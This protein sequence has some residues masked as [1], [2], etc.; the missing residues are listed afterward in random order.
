[1]RR[2]VCFLDKRCIRLTYSK[3]NRIKKFMSFCLLSKLLTKCGN[4]AKT[5]CIFGSFFDV[6][7]QVRKHCRLTRVGVSKLTSVRFKT[8][9]RET[10]KQY[11][12]IIEH[13]TVL[14]CLH[15]FFQRSKCTMAYNTQL[16]DLSKTAPEAKPETST[17]NN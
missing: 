3:L 2:Q 6:F 15:F 13:F 10:I 11:Q 14:M 7:L 4:A 9:Y 17:D 16:N 5:K 1:M 12:T 8:N